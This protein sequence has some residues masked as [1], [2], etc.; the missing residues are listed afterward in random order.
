[1]TTKD[2]KD[3]LINL[4]CEI[5]GEVCNLNVVLKNEEGVVR[6]RKESVAEINRLNEK[7]QDIYRKKTEDEDKKQ[8]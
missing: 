7:L 1:M 5:D 8:K 3:E 6:R 4:I 2:E